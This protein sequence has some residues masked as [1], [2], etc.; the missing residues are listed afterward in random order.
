MLKGDEKNKSDL[1]IRNSA[2]ETVLL[3]MFYI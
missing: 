1:I 2:T 3:D